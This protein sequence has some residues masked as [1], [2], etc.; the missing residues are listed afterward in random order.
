M[1]ES[2]DVPVDWYRQTFYLKPSC[3]LRL[4]FISCLSRVTR[5]V[6][7][8]VLV[9][10]KQHRHNILLSRQTI[11]KIGESEPVY[12]KKDRDQVG[13]NDKVSLWVSVWETEIETKH[14]KSAMIL[15]RAS[16]SQV[17]IPFILGV[18]KGWSLKQISADPI[19][20]KSWF[21]CIDFWF[22]H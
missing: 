17:F 6:S 10:V 4:T 14:Q 5:F 1:R 19:E 18:R 2:M 8:S 3:I 7:C 20:A 16:T 13:W 12:W 15:F 9:V 22:H 11:N 21:F